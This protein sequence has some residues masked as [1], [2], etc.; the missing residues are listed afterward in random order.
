MKGEIHM[1]Q[2]VI[3]LGSNL[4]KRSEHL[5]VAT[6]SL[7]NLPRTNI[8]RISDI[9]ESVPMGY[10]NHPNFLN[11][12]ILL[13]TDFSPN[14]LLG[15]CIGI[16]SAMGRHHRF[17]D[18]PRIID[19]DLIL[20]EDFTEKTEELTV[21]HPRTKER[22]FVLQPLLDIFPDGN[23]LGLDINKHI[24][25]IKDQEIWRRERLRAE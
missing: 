17:K 3:A 8:K 19:L 13:E 6:R 22:L 4:S 20:Y 7:E 14:A 9:Y 16:E 10:N 18:A 23:A 25:K 15:A 21:P 1:K 24:K 2:A 11:A 5:Q 12:V